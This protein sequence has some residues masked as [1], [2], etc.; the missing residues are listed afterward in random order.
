MAQKTRKW[1]PVNVITGPLGVGKTTAINHLLRRRPGNET[2]AVLVNE[3]GLVGVD[4]ALMESEAPKKGRPSVEI[5]EVIGGCI[6]CSAG[7]LFEMALA[8]LL[9]RRLSRRDSNLLA[10]LL[11]LKK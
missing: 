9:Q 10:C 5:R 11:V 7:Y 4:G 6:C 3:Y 2:W 8:Q 1:T